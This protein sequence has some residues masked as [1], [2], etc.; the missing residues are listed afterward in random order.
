MGDSATRSTP[1]SLI[2][3][4]LEQ[5]TRPSPRWALGRVRAMLESR[6]DRDPLRSCRPDSLDGAN[7]SPPRLLWKMKD[8]QREGK[9]DGD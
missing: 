7:R 4:A 8:S 6:D 2:I 1:K 9:V 3:E 5:G